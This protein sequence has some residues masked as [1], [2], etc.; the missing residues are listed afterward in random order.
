MHSARLKL[1]VVAARDGKQRSRAPARRRTPPDA[2]F[3][4]DTMHAAQAELI[5]ELDRVARLHAQRNVD[6]AL[7]LALTRIAAWQA[8]RLG[9][10]YADLERKPRYAAAVVFF[11][12]DLY[13][14]D[15]FARRDA[16]V[17]RVVPMLVRMLPER[18]IATLAEAMELNALAQEFDQALLACLPRA[19]GTFT[20][21][22]YCAAF[23]RVGNRSGRDR[24]VSL[25]TDIGAALDRFVK[26]PFI[27]AALTMMRQ[28]ARVAG[29]SVLH[30]FLERGFDAFRRMG[31]A[32]EFLATIAARET[33]LLDAIFAGNDAPFPAP[34]RRV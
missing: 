3:P 22:E 4:P 19:D 29:M 30:D 28:P 2:F 15:N 7:D 8:C 14:G 10:T 17:A 27:R 24:Q 25:T 6:P 16:D 26:M 1:I 9:E 31:G 34:Q 21:A 5:R 12:T 18:V 32:D 11:E 20:V 33:A 13:G 23:R